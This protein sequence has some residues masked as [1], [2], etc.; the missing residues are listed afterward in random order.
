MVVAPAGE[1]RI[2]WRSSDEARFQPEAGRPCLKLA[3]TIDSGWPT[4]CRPRPSFAHQDRPGSVNVVAFGDG[5]GMAARGA[6]QR[7]VDAHADDAGRPG[8][9]FGWRTRP[10]I[11][12]RS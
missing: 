7:E 3:R 9:D 2:D 11:S 10:R 8:L 4:S 5:S 6:R 12:R 1:N